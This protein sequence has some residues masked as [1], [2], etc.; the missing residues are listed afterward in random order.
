MKLLNK[1][2]KKKQIEEKF[3]TKQEKKRKNQHIKK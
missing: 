3:K 2:A 1:D